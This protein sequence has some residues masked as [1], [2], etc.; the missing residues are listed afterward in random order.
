M[1]TMTWAHRPSSTC[2]WRGSPRSLVFCHRDVAA[3]LFV[4]VTVEGGRV[5]ETTMRDDAGLPFRIVLL[6]TLVVPHP[7]VSF[8]RRGRLRSGETRREVGG[9]TRLTVTTILSLLYGVVLCCCT[10]RKASE[11]VRCQ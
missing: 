4:V 2:C 5:R 7:W 8:G 1:T 10:M 6:T 11:E 9:E 3:R